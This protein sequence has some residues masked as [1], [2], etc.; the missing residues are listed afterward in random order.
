MQA[1]ER[2]DWRSAISSLQTAAELEPGCESGKIIEGN[3]SDDYCPSV[4][5]AEA[6]LGAQE[7]AQAEQ[8]LDVRGKL[9]KGFARR[10]EDIRARV[11]AA[12]SV[13]Q[14]ETA[15]R[16]ALDSIGKKDF[17]GA[18]AQ[19]SALRNVSPAAFR[20]NGLEERLAEANVGMAGTL[21]SDGRSFLALSRFKAAENKFAEAD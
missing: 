8:L 5:L 19:L 16:A 11:K 3:I 15:R 14:F 18:L 7:F 13:A 4:Y 17:A 9:P 1:I 10:A 2:G 6:Y 20:A 21:S 12:S